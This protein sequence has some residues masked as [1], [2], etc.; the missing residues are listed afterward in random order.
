[1]LAAPIGLVLAL[2]PHAIYATYR[3]AP[4]RLWGLSATADQQLGG[5]AMAGEQ[6]IVFFAVFTLWFFRFLTEQEHADDDP[7]R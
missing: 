2:V 4:A 6:A 3:H 1:V 7:P 5:V